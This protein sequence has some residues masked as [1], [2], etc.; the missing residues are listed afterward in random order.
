MPHFL[1]QSLEVSLI[2]GCAAFSLVAARFHL[3]CSVRSQTQDNELG[4]LAGQV[5]M[6]HVYGS[7][8]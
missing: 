6:A 7:L 5:Y 4:L 3:V 1:D 8:R 2:T